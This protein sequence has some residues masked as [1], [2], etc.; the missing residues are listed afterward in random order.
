MNKPVPPLAKVTL[1]Y[2]SL[3]N[4]SGSYIYYQQF[5]ATIHAPTLCRDLYDLFVITRNMLLNIKPLHLPLLVN[6]RLYTVFLTL[7]VELAALVHFSGRR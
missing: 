2:D 5:A 1:S 3:F 7:I 4:A 6:S